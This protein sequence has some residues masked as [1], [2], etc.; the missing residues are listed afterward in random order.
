MQTFVSVG[1]VT[2]P[3]VEECLA[4]AHEMLLNVCTAYRVVCKNSELA[5]DIGNG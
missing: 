4:T 1:S 5:I 3:E 2:P